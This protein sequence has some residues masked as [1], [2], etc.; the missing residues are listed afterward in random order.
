M[1][2]EAVQREF[3]GQAALEA[4]MDDEHRAD[5]NDVELVI[6]VYLWQ[7]LV[8]FLTRW[9]W[10]RSLAHRYIDLRLNRLVL[11]TCILDLKVHL[12]EFLGVLWTALHRL[13]GQCG[14]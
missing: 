5:I 1:L 2:Q 3:H 6:D 10:L 7:I 11:I 9:N 14:I 8:S 4:A 13:C 12:N